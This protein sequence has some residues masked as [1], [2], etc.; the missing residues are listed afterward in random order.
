MNHTFTLRPVKTLALLLACAFCFLLP[1]VSQ[2]TGFAYSLDEEV[3]AGGFT[4]R[5]AF[6]EKTNR[7]HVEIVQGERV[8]FRSGNGA[9][10]KDDLLLGSFSLLGDETKQLLIEE[11]TGEAYCCT[12]NYVLRVGD[13]IDVL[14]SSSQYPVGY[15][16]SPED[17]DGDG[18]FE[19]VTTLT[20]FENFFNMPHEESPTVPVVFR[21]EP[22]ARRYVVGNRVFPDAVLANVEDDK[23]RVRELI[24]ERERTGETP[25]RWR[26]RFTGAVLN[27]A[28]SY[29]Y[30]GDQEKAWSYLIGTY[31][32]E[33]RDTILANLRYYLLRCPIFRG[34]YPD[35]REVFRTSMRINP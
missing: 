35:T 22:D 17:L 13:G 1:G 10:V 33:D 15:G 9:K 28:L 2:E 30:A 7:W 18:V 5:K 34:V 19:L 24:A 21:Y 3:T 12:H 29:F 4:V 26:T 31:D 8:L 20:R 27:V 6:D 14:Y 23:K 16:L 25:N 11:Y 32:L